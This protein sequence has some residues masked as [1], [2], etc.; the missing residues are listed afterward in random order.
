M[1]NGRYRISRAAL[2]IAFTVEEPRFSYE[3]VKQELPKE[4]IFQGQKVD[5][6]VELKNTGNVIWRNYGSN[7]IRLGTEFPRDHK[8]IFVKKNPARIGYLLES[9]VPPGQIGRF[10]LELDVPLKIEKRVVERFTPVIEGVRWLEDKNLGFSATIKKP[11]HLARIRRLDPPSKML[12]GEMKKIA[13][14]IENKGD[15]TWNSENMVATLTTRGLTLFKNRLVP[16]DEEIKPKTA[17]TFDFWVQ[18]PYR[19]GR[20]S[21]NIASKFNRVPIRGGSTRMLIEVPDPKLRAQVVDQGERS[22]SL[23]PGQVKELTV[24]IKNLSNAVWQKEGPSAIY[25]APSEPQDRKSILFLKNSWISPARVTRMKE[26]SVGPGETATFA[27]SVK[28]DRKGIYKEYF[29][30]VIE[31]VGWLPGSVVRWD[32]RIFGDKIEGQTEDP[33]TDARENA[34]QAEVI[35]RGRVDTERTITYRPPIVQEKPIRIK[36]SYNAENSIFTSPQPYDVTDGEGNKLL[37]VKGNGS[38]TLTRVGSAFRLEQGSAIRSSSMVRFAPTPEEGIMEMAS[39]EHR[40]SWNASLNDNKFR[41]TIEVRLVGE[42]VTY[43]NELP[44]EDY[45]KGLAE[46]SQDTSLEK[47]KALAVLARTYSR[48]YMQ[49]ENRKFP[50]MPY[51][52]SDDPD[53]F[54]KYLGYG[55]ELRM[56]QFVGAV[57]L[58]TNEVVTYEGKLVKTPY[59][60][61]SDGRTRSAQEVW[62]WTDTPYLQSVDDPWCQGLEKKG[63]GVGLSGCGAEAQAKEGKTYDDIIKYYYQG[64]EVQEVGLK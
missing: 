59:F 43:I 57:A 19:G 9:E 37:E 58:T 31:K 10:V 24:K 47:M 16:R 55:F 62:G 51:D 40:P 54:Q 34:R 61:Q 48:F 20:H 36:L 53:I 50:D 12:P 60:N 5:A 29:Q 25:L 52:G 44:L 63:H 41:G 33:L 49:S 1:V 39:W 26:E 42:A 28:S 13:V 56:P 6:W 22:I 3:T 21:L 30:L 35:T 45:L 14:E 8:S 11:I 18:A 4:I 15:L 23:Q 2:D 17:S 7:P 46:A 38:V 32:F 27:F 64:V